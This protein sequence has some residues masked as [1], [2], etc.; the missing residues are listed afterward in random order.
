M[1][2]SATKRYLSS[3]R[4]DIAIFGVLIRDVLPKKSDLSN[5]AISLAT[6]CPSITSIALYAL[7]IPQNTISLLQ[8]KA[9][10]VLQGG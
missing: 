9:Q 1:Y 8:S 4:T 7:Y 10:Q 6:D 3:G 2:E 5:F